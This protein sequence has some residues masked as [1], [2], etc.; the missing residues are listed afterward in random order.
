MPCEGVSKPA[1]NARAAGSASGNPAVSLAVKP[2]TTPFGMPTRSA[3]DGRSF[4]RGHLR[5]AAKRGAELAR[6]GI[7]GTGSARAKSYLHLGRASGPVAGAVAV[8]N[9]GGRKGRVAIVHYVEPDATVIYLNLS[10]RRQAGHEWLFLSFIFFSD[11][12][13]I[14]L[15]FDVV[16]GFFDISSDDAAAG[17]L[18]S[19]LVPL[20]VPA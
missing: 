3:A 13:F 11:E 5:C 18:E 20:A 15:P 19:L 10:S 12:G 14:I 2:S 4:T 7:R 1:A 6:R 17:G 16:S 8:F 9:R